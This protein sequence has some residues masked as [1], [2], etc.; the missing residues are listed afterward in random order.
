MRAERPPPSPIER[1]VGLLPTRWPVRWRLT[2]VSAGLT[3]VILVVFALAVGRLASNRITSDFREELQATADSLALQLRSGRLTD[4][5][6]QRMAITR[7]AAIRIVHA[8]GAI[9]EQTQGA[10]GLG[11][12]T[13][14]VTRVGDMEVASTPIAPGGIPPLFVQYAREHDDVATTIDRLWLLLA[15]GVAGG[16]G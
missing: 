15:L 5:D 12:P 9:E 4:F 13:R 6:L 16:T 10:P 8:S 14:G 11:V 2:V 3:F 7:H 1:L